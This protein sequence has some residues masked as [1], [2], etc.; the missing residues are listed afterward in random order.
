MKPLRDASHLEHS[1]TLSE[2]DHRYGDTVHILNDP[3]MSTQLAR[4]C[5]QDTTQPLIHE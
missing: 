5:S 4:L 3:F 1:Y 2:L